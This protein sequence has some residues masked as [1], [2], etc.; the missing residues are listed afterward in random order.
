VRRY[1]PAI[2]IAAFVVFVLAMSAPATAADTATLP[3]LPD[4][5]TVQS[6][7]LFLAFL[8]PGFV[9]VQVYSLLV[10]TTPSDF[11]SRINELFAYSAIHYALTIWFVLWSNWNLIVIYAVVFVVPICWPLLLVG[12]R[13][14]PL[15]RSFPL[16]DPTP[17]DG[18]FAR[19]ARTPNERGLFVRAKTKSGDLVAGYYGRK[20]LSSTFPN[21]AQLYLEVAYVI[22]P[23]GSTRPM[24]N[25]AG[26]IINCADAE[27][28]IFRNE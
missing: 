24:N 13:R 12:I 26:V 28:V 4:L 18:F 21:P 14:S 23:D 8:I 22:N 10:P 2:G 11:S 6:L 16:P 27:Y 1:G 19:H 25:T 15:M 17:W 9:S 20:S 5:T 7:L 3:K